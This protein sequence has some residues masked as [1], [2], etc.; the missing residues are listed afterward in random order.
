MKLPSNGMLANTFSLRRC[1]YPLRPLTEFAGVRLPGQFVRIWADSEEHGKP[2]VNGSDLMSLAALGTLGEKTRYLPRVT[3]VDIE[4]LIIR[5]GWLALTCSGTI[6]RVFYIPARFDGWVATPDLIRVI[7]NKGTDVGF[8]HAYLSSP[9]AQ[10]QILGHTYGGQIDH[11]TDEQIGNIL[12]P[13]LP[14]TWRIGN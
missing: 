8:L 1:Q 4:A 10:A 5:K 7:P 14:C 9:L 6:G 13:V 3:D 12:M 11:V 2:Y